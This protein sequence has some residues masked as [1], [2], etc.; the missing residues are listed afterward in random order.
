M[1]VKPGITAGMHGAIRRPSNVGWI[2]RIYWLMLTNVHAAV[3]VSQ[4]FFASPKA[5][6][7]R[8]AIIWLYT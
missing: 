6:A 3:P 7:S 1:T 8:P 5:A 2:P 4:L